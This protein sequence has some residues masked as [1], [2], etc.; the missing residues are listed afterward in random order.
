MVMTQVGLLCQLSLHNR[1]YNNS[2][3]ILSDC[4]TEQSDVP[5]IINKIYWKSA[6]VIAS[7]VSYQL[8]IHELSMKMDQKETT[9]LPGAQDCL[10]WCQRRCCHLSL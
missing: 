4:S 3:S 10:L 9:V 7:H 2:L 6:H 5:E 1:I 8:M